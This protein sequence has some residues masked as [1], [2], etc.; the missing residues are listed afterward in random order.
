MSSYENY[1]QTKEKAYNKKA[2]IYRLLV[3]YCP[4]L[5]INFLFPVAR[6]LDFPTK[7]SFLDIG[8]GTGLYSYILRKRGHEIDE[9]EP[10][11]QNLYGNNEVFCTRFEDYKTTKKYDCILLIDVLE[12]I[13]P[14]EMTIALSKLSSLLERD[15]RLM[16]KVPNCGSISGLESHFGDLTHMW[17]F[18]QTSLRILLE[19][20]NF[21]IITMGGLKPNFSLR[22]FLYA[23]LAAPFALFLT[24]YLKSHGVH[25]ELHKPSIFCMAKIKKP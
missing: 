4:K 9:V 6:Y 13:E 22:R 8:S 2:S 11:L 15:G 12:H 5:L 18:N 20:N 10:Y 16:I 24:L 19:N 25:G 3:D 1:A 23:I 14:N 7:K 17:A 21:D